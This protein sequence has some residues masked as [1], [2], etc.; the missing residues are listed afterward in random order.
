VLKQSGYA[1]GG[2]VHD[3]EAE[4]KELIKKELGK[5]RIKVRAGGKVEG[6]KPEHRPDR[7]A[8]GGSIDSGL[9]GVA[10]V[11][12]RYEAE[13]IDQPHGPEHRADGGQ[14]GMHRGGKG[15][16]PKNITIIVGKGGDDD[17]KAQMAHQAGLQQGAQIGAKMAAGAGGP[18]RPPIGP[19]GGGPMP[20]GSPIAGPPPGAGG[21]P[22]P[23][24][25]GMPPQMARDGGK[26]KV[27][28]HERRAGGTV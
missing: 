2:A 21:P 6:K 10:S 20:G 7:R 15:K 1:T 8:R 18:P 5:A 25:P 28:A 11:D 3:D 16:G 9:N 17:G 4:D 22:M 14:T 23:P 27:R 12:R 19:P 26:I 24:R 13:G